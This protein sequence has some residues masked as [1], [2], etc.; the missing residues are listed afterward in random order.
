MIETTTSSTSGRTTTNISC[1]KS[2]NNYNNS[3]TDEIIIKR[4]EKLHH[5]DNRELLINKTDLLYFNTNEFKTKELLNVPFLATTT[6]T[7]HQ[8]DFMV[9]NI[10]IF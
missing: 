5:R 9:F 1:L 6:T 10:F 7:S 2:F 4:K 3:N 8:I